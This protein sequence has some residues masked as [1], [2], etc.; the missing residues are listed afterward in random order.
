MINLRRELVPVRIR[1]GPWNPGWMTS[2]DRDT[3]LVLPSLAQG[4]GN[5]GGWS[6]AILIAGFGQG[7]VN[8]YQLCGAFTLL[9]SGISSRLHEGDFLD[10]LFAQEPLCTN[11]GLVLRMFLW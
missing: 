11:F 7:L 5:P 10:V 8:W 3:L 4:V 1:I 6:I 2:S 9:R